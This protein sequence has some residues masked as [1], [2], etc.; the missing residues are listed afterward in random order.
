MGAGLGEVN[1][2]QC[3][4]RD[5]RR[6][7][8]ASESYDCQCCGHDDARC[9]GLGRHPSCVGPGGGCEEEEQGEVGQPGWVCCSV[10]DARCGGG[11]AVVALG[12]PG[13]RWV[14]LVRWVWRSRWVKAWWGLAL[15]HWITGQWRSVSPAM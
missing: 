10:Y 4:R 13:H 1:D 15:S 8:P 7:G 12:F 14:R 2:S 6:Y 3:S 9:R 11:C 5:E